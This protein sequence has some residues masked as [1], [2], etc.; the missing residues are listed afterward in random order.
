MMPSLGLGLWAC[1]SLSEGLHNV[2]IAG[3]IVVL[4]LGALSCFVD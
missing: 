2:F 1:A 4:G 3:I